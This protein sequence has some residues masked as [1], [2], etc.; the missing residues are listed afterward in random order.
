M[1][2]N[3]VH[4][5]KVLELTAPRTVKSGEGAQVGSI[6]GVA[7]NDYTSG[8]TACP[9]AVT[10]VWDIAKDSSLFSQGDNVYWDNSGHTATSTPGS[11]LLIGVAEATAA[12]LDDTVRVKLTE[13]PFEINVAGAG[14][15]ASAAEI[16]VLHSVVAGTARASSG[17]VLDANKSIDISQVTTQ[18]SLGGTGVPGAAVVQT[19][20][21]KKVTGLSN[22]TATDVL[23]VTVPN[24]QHAALIDVDVLGILGAGGT[25]GAGESFI[26]SKYQIVVGRTA[27]LATVAVVSSAIGGQKGAVSGGDAMTSAVVTVST[28]TGA[29][30]AT[31]TYTIKVAVTKASGASD[32]H[33]AVVSARIVNENATGITIA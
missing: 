4:E 7:M 25:I 30:S 29:T 26:L 5:G 2:Q 1:A 9:F 33:V 22:A 19:E 32:N 3:F 12:A 31:Q 16:N 15:T 21:T 8:D 20:V 10:G 27:G 6:F 17:A 28:M 11:N 14:V 18:R 24:A 23:T 13:K